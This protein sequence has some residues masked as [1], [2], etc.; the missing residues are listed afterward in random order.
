VLLGLAQAWTLDSPLPCP[1]GQNGYEIYVPLY[2]L[3]ITLSMLMKQT[4]RSVVLNLSFLEHYHSF[5]FSFVVS[6]PCLRSKCFALLGKRQPIHTFVASIHDVHHITNL[7]FLKI[8]LIVRVPRLSIRRKILLPR[9][10]SSSY[11][12]PITAYLYFAPPA[13]K[14]AEATDLVLD[15]PGGGFVAMSPA[16]HEERLR[17][18]AISTRRPVLS[19]DYGKA[20]ECQG[21][22]SYF[23]ANTDTNVKIHT[24]LPLMK[25]L[26]RIG[27][28]WNLVSA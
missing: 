3:Y 10:K 11:T 18:W 28:L 13:H 15:Y 17:M 5:Y 25:H 16:H 22:T 14:L 27:Y 6:E 7:L 20:P 12:R 4:K 21:F 9:P 2:F 19:I 1:F 26:I 24:P 23:V 8:R